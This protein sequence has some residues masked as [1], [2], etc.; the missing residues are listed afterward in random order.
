M[1]IPEDDIFV[2]DYLTKQIHRAIDERN[3]YLVD[4]YSDFL[5]QEHSKYDNATESI[6]LPYPYL[7]RSTH[8]HEVIVRLIELMSYAYDDGYKDA[9]DIIKKKL[10]EE[11]KDQYDRKWER[12]EKKDC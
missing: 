3:E 12:H 5:C 4:A 7:L 8:R 2:L 6:S 1:V 9:G 10:Y 11:H